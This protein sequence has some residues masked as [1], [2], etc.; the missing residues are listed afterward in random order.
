MGSPHRSVGGSSLKSR[1][2]TGLAALDYLPPASTVCVSSA[3]GGHGLTSLQLSEFRKVTVEF[4][5]V[6]PRP[7]PLL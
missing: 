6:D 2:L 7:L 1:F 4:R 3:T 5:A